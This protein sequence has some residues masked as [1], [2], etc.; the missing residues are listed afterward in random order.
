MDVISVSVSGLVSLIQIE[1][2]S[3]SRQREL[4]IRFQT[5]NILFKS[6]TLFNLI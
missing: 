2:Q 1:Q 6:N 4:E 3:I 5:Q